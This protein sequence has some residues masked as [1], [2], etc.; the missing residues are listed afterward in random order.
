MADTYFFTGR[1]RC[2]TP[3]KPA[4]ASN[5]PKTAVS[6]GS[7]TQVGIALGLQCQF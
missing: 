4:L 5:F 3:N 2:Y 7:G 6:G 1:L